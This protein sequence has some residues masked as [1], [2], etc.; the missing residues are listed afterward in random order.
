MYRLITLGLFIVTVNGAAI[1]NHVT[2]TPRIHSSEQLL[3]AIVNDCLEINGISCMKGKV[4]TYLDTVLG[5]RSE[6]ARAFNDNNVDKVI[7]DRVGRILASNEIR[8]EL[9]QVIFGDAAVT[10]RPDHGLD[11]DVSEKEEGLQTKQKK[12]I[13]FLKYFLQQFP[14]DY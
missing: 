6:Q 2:E 9:P 7:Y 3:T 10:Y 1:S 13:N 5:L 14:V 11:F 8:V 4:L 12:M